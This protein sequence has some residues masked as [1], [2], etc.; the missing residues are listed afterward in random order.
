MVPGLMLHHMW[1]LPKSGIKPLSPALV[2]GFSILS[3]QGSSALHL[4][5]NNDLRLKIVIKSEFEGQ[6]TLTNVSIQEKK[7]RFSY[8]Q[9]HFSLESPTFTEKKMSLPS[10]SDFS[11][12]CHFASNSQVQRS[13]FNKSIIV[14]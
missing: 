9:L 13:F 7:Q 5:K 10:Y 6:P 14:L 2:G 11:V 3:H 4:F 12:Q 1:D 8:V